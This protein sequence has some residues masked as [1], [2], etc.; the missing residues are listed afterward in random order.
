MNLIGR[1]FSDCNK[2]LKTIPNRN[3][4]FDGEKDR[5]IYENCVHPEWKTNFFE[6]AEKQ[7]DERD[8]NFRHDLKKISDYFEFRTEKNL[9]TD[10]AV[11]LK[12]YLKL[13]LKL[14]G[15]LKKEMRRLEN[16]NKENRNSKL[17][18]EDL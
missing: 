1:D 3:I 12:Q 13:R 5:F 6:F 18:K 4:S 11:I 8:D 10:T 17:K 9:T 14:I 7:L 15:V 16:I 2:L